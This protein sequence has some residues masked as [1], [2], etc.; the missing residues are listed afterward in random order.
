VVLAVSKVFAQHMSA[1]ACYDDFCKHYE[2]VR[3]AID[4]AQDAIEEWSVPASD[5]L[6]YVLTC[7]AGLPTTARS[8]V[9]PSLSI[10]CRAATPTVERH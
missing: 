8:R 1:F 3:L 10:P 5:I 2:L 9:S 4:Q 6:A 7:D